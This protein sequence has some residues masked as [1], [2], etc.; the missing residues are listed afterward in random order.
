MMSRT[1]FSE[2][3]PGRSIFGGDN[4]CVDSVTEVSDAPVSASKTRISSSIDRLLAAARSFNRALTSSGRFRM[5]RLAK[6][7]SEMI[8]LQS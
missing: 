5:V 1:R 7:T 6:T 8:A 3:C 2:F 4:D